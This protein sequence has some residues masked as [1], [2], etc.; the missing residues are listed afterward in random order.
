MMND[1]RVLLLTGY[2][3]LN[4]I[5]DDN[6][7]KEVY[8][9]TLPSKQRYADRHGY[10]LLSMRSFGIDKNNRFQKTDIGFLRADMAFEMLQYY[11]IVMWID[12]DSIITNLNYSID[13][14]LIEPEICFYA[15][16]DWNAKLT[17]STGNFI[18]KRTT[19]TQKF[20][21]LFYELCQYFPQEQD[22]LN[23][24]YFKTQFQSIMK[25]L[26]HKFLGAI[27]S[28]DML[29]QQLWRDRMP[30]VSPWT[31]DCFLSHLTGISNKDR[32]NIL[33]KFYKDY[34]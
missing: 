20:I 18:I 1:K 33:N 28:I 12:A 13:D 2:T 15:S 24:I 31:S 10:D 6:T 17:F 21:S 5:S 23:A 32:I 34:L 22:T 14:F 7:M 3:D 26:E 27:P 8:D 4:P 11:D 16:Y 30:I 25:I 19:N 29:G 9:L